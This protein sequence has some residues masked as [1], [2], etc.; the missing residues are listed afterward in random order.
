MGS[1]TVAIMALLLLLA[2]L[3]QSLVPSVA[4]LGSAKM[5]F[6]LGVPIY[7]ALVHRRGMVVAA[8]LL[9]G[10]LQDSMSPLPV[11]FSG[12]CFVVS[13]L[14]IHQAREVLFRDSPFTVAVLGAGVAAVGTL[15][16]YVMLR[17]GTETAAVPLWWLG[18]TMGGNGLLG[19]VAVPLVWWVAGSLDRR[20]GVEHEERM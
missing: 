17:L 14:A 13:G 7:Y 10:I 19:I 18:L 20:A 6:L 3:A 16:V 8:A 2:A 11:G 5:P 15:M 1:V 12:L 9:A 4:S